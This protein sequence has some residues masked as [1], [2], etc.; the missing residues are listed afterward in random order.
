MAEQRCWGIF[1]H[2]SVKIC[3]LECVCFGF[4]QT[5]GTNYDALLSNT[6]HSAKFLICPVYGRITVDS[7]HYVKP[8]GLVQIRPL[9]QESHLLFKLDKCKTQQ[10]LEFAI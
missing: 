1:A 2:L 5:T 4:Y 6:Y 7:G 9:F 3:K 8:Y 10:I